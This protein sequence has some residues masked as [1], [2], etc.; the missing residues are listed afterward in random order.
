M[1]GGSWTSK[2]WSKYTASSGITSKSTVKD[3]YKAVTGKKEFDPKGIEFRE[4]CDSTEHPNSTP[5]ILGLDVTGSMGSVLESVAKKLNVLVEQIY[6]RKPV[7]DPQ[8]MVAAFGD[9]TFD[10]VPLQVTQFESDIRIAEQL[11]D[12]YFERGGGGNDGESYSLPWYFASRHTKTDSF[13]KHN[14]KGFIFTMGDEPILDTLSKEEIKKFIGDDVQ[15]DLSSEQLLNE[16]SRKYEVYHLM[17]TEGSY[18]RYKNIKKI[19]KWVDLLGQR[20]IT[21]TSIDKIP[22]IIVSILEIA[23]GKDK[24]EVINSWDG[25]TSVAVRNATESLTTAVNTGSELIEFV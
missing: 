2:D 21:V 23:S 6:D 1:G 12:I 14:K 11:K 10:D 16:V 5:I 4:S 9:S 17:I 25:D 18:M 3:I 13:D 15:S 24:E 7:T 19:N 22:E 8:I 20:A